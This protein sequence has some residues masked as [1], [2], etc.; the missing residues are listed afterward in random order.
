MPTKMPRVT[1]AIS[2]EELDRVE[3]FQKA[4]NIKNQS[5]AVIQLIRMGFNDSGKENAAISHTEQP[6]VEPI[7]RLTAVVEK[8]TPDQARFMVQL[9]EHLLAL[10]PDAYAAACAES[11]NLWKG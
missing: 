11:R 6:T 8:L 3:M 10:N 1:F 5:Q 2:Q 4:N 9:V 7:D